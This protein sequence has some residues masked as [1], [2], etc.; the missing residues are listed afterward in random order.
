MYI[1]LLLKEYTTLT[2]IYEIRVQYIGSGHN[3]RSHKKWKQ[4]KAPSILTRF[5]LKQQEN[6]ISNYL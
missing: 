3:P 1:V 5:F 4:I 2:L 6:Q